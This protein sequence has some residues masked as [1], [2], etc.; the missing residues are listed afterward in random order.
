MKHAFSI[1]S[2]TSVK[3]PRRT[4]A[5][6]RSPPFFS[7]SSFR[8]LIKKVIRISDDGVTGSYLSTVVQKKERQFARDVVAQT[9]RLFL[10]WMCT[11]GGSSRWTLVSRTAKELGVVDFLRSTSVAFLHSKKRETRKAFVRFD[12]AKFAKI[13]GGQPRPLSTD[14]RGETKVTFR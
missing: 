1:L 7:A 5:D 9:Y 2:P 11:S 4:A 10:P 14:S 13:D 3:P 12:F 6:K 8:D